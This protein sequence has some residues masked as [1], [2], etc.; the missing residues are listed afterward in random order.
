MTPGALI[1]GEIAGNAY[2][3]SRLLDSLRS[4]TAMAF[5]GAGASM[6]LYS[7]WPDL[8]AF[9]GREAQRRGLA[10]NDDIEF[11]GL[12]QTPR[13]QQ[14][15]RMIR[16][17]FGENATFLAVLKEYFQAKKSEETGAFFTETQRLIA[18][19]PFKG[20]VTTNY[21]PGLW[22]ALLACQ[23]Q[24]RSQSVATWDDEDIVNSWYTKDI[25]HKAD[26]CPI[27]HIHGFWEH[28][29][30]IIL[31]NDKYRKVYGLG[32]FKDMFR[33]LWS[34]ER[35]V[36]VGCGFSDTWMDRNL[37]EILGQVAEIAD[38][39]HVA[40]IG[41]TEQDEKHIARYR[42]L[43]QNMYR[44]E[45][46]FYRIKTVFENGTKR[47]DHS[48]LLTV[49]TDI[50]IELNPKKELDENSVEKIAAQPAL[51]KDGILSSISLFNRNL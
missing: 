48:D 30:T 47:S 4:R 31:D 51:D 3:R 35:L 39:R 46:I 42:S 23:P 26:L 8:L 34:Q 15:A 20:M 11:W 5:V 27:L 1:G 50:S 7:G 37:D 24:C 38:A 25:F 29:D 36:L 16:Q 17:K 32:Y 44:I 33:S 45:I 18:N 12:Q 41:I 49:L 43:M 9:L 14:V 13:P 22:N 10:D 6:E 2:V 40:F 28:P 21:D 19:L